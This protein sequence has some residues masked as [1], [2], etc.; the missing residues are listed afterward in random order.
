MA[1]DIKSMA[2]VKLP[3]VPPK[4]QSICK[5]DEELKCPVCKKLYVRPVLLSC[6]HSL[7]Y[8]C[9]SS[10]K[11]T[12][13][14]SARSSSSDIS[15]NLDSDKVSFYSD[16]DS[17][18]VS[19]GS[20]SP[21][22][23]SCLAVGFANHNKLSISCPICGRLTCVDSQGADGLTKNKVLEN[24]LSRSIDSKPLDA[25]CQ[26]CEG[27]QTANASVMCEQCEVYYCDA[28][29]E[30]CH[31]LRGPL[32]KH[33]LVSASDGQKIL[34][35]REKERG[36]ETKCSKHSDETLSMY[37][38]TCYAAA[39]C[40]CAS[41]RHLEHDIQPLGATMKT[42]KVSHLSK[43]VVTFCNPY[44]IANHTNEIA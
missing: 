21:T 26:L 1:G 8:G 40:I 36:G 15:D 42:Y 31:P 28:C 33:R 24:V 7:C 43:L 10:L 13:P 27:V 23:A 29:R 41:S 12:V 37:C 6:A 18:V 34:Q 2:K 35:A 14:L 3:V 20:N 38:L 25:K 5:F 11:T 16:T 44:V 4:R 9:V 22:S 19:N 30:R 32:A 39:C 17:G